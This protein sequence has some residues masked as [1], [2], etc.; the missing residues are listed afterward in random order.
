MHISFLFEVA[1]EG[2]RERFDFLVQ[3]RVTPAC[4]Y[5]MIGISLSPMRPVSRIL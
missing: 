5:P 1:M 2:E 3:D 4:I